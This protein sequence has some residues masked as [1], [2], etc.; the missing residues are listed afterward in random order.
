MGTASAPRP[1]RPRTMA[2]ATGIAL[3]AGLLL[4]LAYPADI[5]FKYDEH[6][7]FVHATSGH[8]DYSP[9][10][11]MRSSLGVFNPGLSA[12]VF[13]AL[14]AVSRATTPVALARAVQLTNGLALA[15]AALFAW[16]CVRRDEREPWLWGIGLG[17]VNP[18]AVVFARKIW[19]QSLLPIFTLTALVGWWHRDRRWGACL[20]GVV[21]AC[22][23]QVH[24]SGFFLT[25]GF[26]LW[27]ALFDR[28]AT[29]WRWWAA[30]M[31]LGLLPM[32][33]WIVYLAGTFGARSSGS[34]APWRVVTPVY[35]IFW[36]TEPLGIG[37]WS[38]L[39]WHMLDFLRSGPLCAVGGLHV[40]AIGLGVA[41]WRL[42]ARRRQEVSRAGWIGRD[43][44]GFAT[45]AVFLGC[46]GLMTLSM[47]AVHR[48][49]VYVT[50]PLEFVWLAALVVGPGA[51]EASRRLARRLLAALWVVECLITASFLVYIH[52]HN[53][54]PGAD[55]GVVYRAQPP[56]QTFLP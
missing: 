4:R 47:L 41:V 25:G 33:P 24:V 7:L 37:L 6:W 28:R 8:A 53:G 43:P 45:S 34:F 22:M 9:W 39:G 1:P 32:A 10:L 20:W 35:W 30:G 18:M 21:G 31:L 48:S 5:E 27:A 17:A 55:Y 52:T 14:A 50:F 49:Y 2:L 44:T 42:I 16:T 40:A 13:T 29:R 46:G 26:A 19:Q 11:G 56:G 12:W 3:T 51:P 15:L 36:F 38:S 54:A 23:G